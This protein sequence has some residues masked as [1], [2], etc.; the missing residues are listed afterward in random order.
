MY[1]IFKEKI[2]I[3]A[4]L[5]QLCIFVMIYNISKSSK[6]HLL[7]WIMSS[8]KLYSNLD[9]LQQ[10]KILLVILLL[11]SFSESGMG[12]NCGVR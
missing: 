6:N 2:V 7:S 12:E 8:A 3:T 10:L 11:D 9:L 4:F 1:T 5:H